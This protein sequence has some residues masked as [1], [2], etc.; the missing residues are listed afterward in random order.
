MAAD[1]FNQVIEQL[2]LGPNILIVLPDN[3][4]GDN[5]AAG[6][7]LR[8]FLRKLDKEVTVA[9]PSSPDSKFSFLEGFDQVSIGLSITKNFVIELSTKHAQVD[10]LSYKKESDKLAIY[11]KPKNGEFRDTDVSFNTADYPYSHII[12]IGIASLDQLGEFYTK[13]AEM[14]FKTP[15]INVDYRAANEAY[16]QFNLIQLSSTSNSEVIMDLI[17]KFDLKPALSMKTLPPIFWLALSRKPTAS[18]IP[19]L[20][21]RLSLKLLSW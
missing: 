11:I 19:G 12:T 4:S 20:R 21:L 15:I 14:F 5:L 10:E 3:S 7:A 13:N 18:S 1:I 8:S 2:N 17:Y 16:G 6:L 9:S